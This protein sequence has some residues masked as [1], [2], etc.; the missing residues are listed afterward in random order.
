MTET[1][2]AI[3]QADHELR[4]CDAYLAQ[5]RGIYA[6]LGEV[7]GHLE[8]AHKHIGKVIDANADRSD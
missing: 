2:R 7:L 6:G 5:L 4:H 8:A 3:A 1:E